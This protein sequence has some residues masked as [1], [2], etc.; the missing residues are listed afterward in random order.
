MRRLSSH[1]LLIASQLVFTLPSLAIDKPGGDV[2]EFLGTA[3]DLESELPF[4]LCMGGLNHGKLIVY[5]A[6]IE[7]L[8]RQTSALECQ[9]EG[10]KPST[11][12]DLPKPKRNPEI[13]A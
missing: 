6:Q 8:F 12:P 3:I 4:N 1:A 2:S 7:N 5:D 13:L 9:I 11:M 10:G